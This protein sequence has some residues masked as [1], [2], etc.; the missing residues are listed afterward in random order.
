M[1]P[2]HR[3]A[4]RVASGVGE[5]YDRA[6]NV[7]VTL[8]GNNFVR[9]ALQT[10]TAGRPVLYHSTFDP[11]RFDAQR[12]DAALARMAQDGYNVARV[13]INELAVAKGRSP[14]PAYVRNVAEFLRLAKGRGVLVLLT[15]GGAVPGYTERLYRFTQGID[16]SNLQYLTRG[17]IDADREFWLDFIGALIDL[18]APTDD[19]LGYDLRNEAYFQGDAPPFSS[20]SGTVAAANG[21]SYDM[22]RADEKE[23]LADDGIVL[24][25]NEVRGAIRSIDPTALVTLSFFAPTAPHPWRKGDPRLVRSAKVIADADAGGS[26]LD[27]I[28]LHSYPEHLPLPDLMDN[29][30]A[31]AARTKPLLMGEFGLSQSSRT[32]TAQAAELLVVWQVASCRFGFAGWLLWTWDTDEQPEFRTALGDG[33]LIGAALAPRTRADPCRR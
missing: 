1:P 33:G 31:T 10:N 20:A 11:G 19:V 24:W 26:S 5:L 25:A 9:L 21:K 32:S 6:T 22:S 29:F 16:F 2:A 13:F 14:D 15:I 27:F 4:V 23:R 17:G 28:D 18:G 7:N 8:R 30:G 12:A 3:I